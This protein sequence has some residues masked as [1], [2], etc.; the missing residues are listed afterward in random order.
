M[1]IRSLITMFSIE[2]EQSV[3]H[4]VAVTVDYVIFESMHIN[5]NQIV[6]HIEDQGL[7]AQACYKL[8]EVDAQKTIITEIATYAM[9]LII[10]L[11]GIK[12]KRNNAN[13][14][15]DLDVPPVLPGVLVKLRHSAFVR[16]VL[17]LYREHLAKFWLPQN[18]DQIE[19]D[20][21]ALL[22]AYNTNNVLR[23]T[24]DSHGVVTTFNDTWGCAPG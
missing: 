2:I 12:A 9:M 6:V 17:D 15:L 1:L 10:G 8:L 18:I 23:A 21:Y 7:F 19:A 14:G 11:N 20:H 24:I 22:K 5:V 3:A 4:I 13:E 16:K